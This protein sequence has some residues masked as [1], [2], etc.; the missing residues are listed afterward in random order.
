[1]T[2]GHPSG[3]SAYTVPGWGGRQPVNW[4]G[5]VPAVD[6][7][8]LR[9]GPRPVVAV[10]DTGIGEH[11]WLTDD[12]VQHDV[13]VLGEP[14][15]LPTA[16]ELA[17]GTDG[18]L[19]GELA[20]DAGHGTFIA[21]LVRQAC[22]M[23]LILDIRLYGDDG[24]VAEYDL[25]RNLQLLALRQL[26]ARTGASKDAAVDVVAL[27]LGY[28]HEQPGDAAFDALLHGPIRL[29]GRYGAAVVVSA[30]NDATDR[31]IYPAAF[32]PYPGGVVKDEPGVVPVTAVGAL[33]P[34]GSIALF[35]NDG[36]WVAFHRPGASLVSTMPTTYDASIEPDQ[37]VRNARGELRTSLDID[38]FSSGFGIWSGTSFAAPLFAGQL[39]ARLGKEY[40]NGRTDLSRNASVRRMRRLL[41]D[42]PGHRDKVAAERAAA[43]A[44]P[45]ER[46]VTK[47]TKRATEKATR[48]TSA[49]RKTA[50]GAKA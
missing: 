43:A 18:S 29:L 33:N 11:P 39:A 37:A 41:G 3:L 9:S 30:G 13:R 49:A 7:K 8:R 44:K 16:A 15:G 26:R 42:M 19:L 6:K 10:L 38:D 31:P 40:D 17:A 47:A 48:K 36:P 23:A 45:A 24:V 5:P 28:Y 27:S 21:G 46:T 34:D 1:V 12:F 2:Q 32:A 22:P 25:L 14:L 4:T 35:S 50:K 20:R